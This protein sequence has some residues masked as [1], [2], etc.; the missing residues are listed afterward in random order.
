MTTDESS[1]ERRP[2]RRTVMKYGALAT[3]GALVGGA[4]SAGTV[5]ADGDER[6][7]TP[8][9]GVMFPYQFTPG[10]RFS[11]VESDLDWRPI[12]VDADYR[13]HV[14][15]YEFA[16]S[17]RAFLFTTGDGDQPL[18]QDRPLAFGAAPHP[19]SLSADRSLVG[20]DV[21]AIE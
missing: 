10:A 4:Q 18:P 20:V 13:S 8:V 9:E 15:E 5:D 6:D 1:Q 17:L 7:P 3:T 21:T 16:R 14:I 19:T 11:V 12:G 2:S